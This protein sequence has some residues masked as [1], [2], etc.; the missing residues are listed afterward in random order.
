MKVN[1]RSSKNKKYDHS[2]SFFEMTMDTLRNSSL[3]KGYW[4]LP[5]ISASDVEM[6]SPVYFK[7]LHGNTVKQTIFCY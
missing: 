1:N 6:N 3:N 2:F 5:E 4:M 7:I